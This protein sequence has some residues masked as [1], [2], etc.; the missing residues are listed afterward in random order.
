MKYRNEL[1]KL[2]LP[3]RIEAYAKV[4]Q[5]VN[6]TT[7]NI[8]GTLRDYQWALAEAARLAIQSHNTTKQM[9]TPQAA[10]E[11]DAVPTAE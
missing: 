3:Q 8:E 6:T 11:T 5:N 4:E 7:T 1:L 10:P 9:D 2:L